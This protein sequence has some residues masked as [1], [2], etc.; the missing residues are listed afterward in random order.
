MHSDLRI[1]LVQSRLLWEDIPGN[2]A[3]FT[4]KI[5]TIPT[6]STD[7]I[8]LPETF[9]TGFSMHT[10]ELAEDEEGPSL[11]WMRVMASEKQAVVAGSIIFREGEQYF[12][13]FLWV[14]PD[15]S[16]SHYN[17]RHC[18]TLAGEQEHFTPGNARLIVECKGWRLCPM[19]CY[20]LRFPVWSRYRGDYDVLLYVANWPRPRNEAWKT[21]LRGRA[22]ENQCYTIGVNR[23]G[24]DEKGLAY[25]G[26]S[27]VIDYAGAPLYQASEVEGIFTLSLSAEKQ[28]IFRKKLAF[29]ADRDIFEVTI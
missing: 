6:G 3:A 29:L 25:S 5:K 21:L 22:I 28:Q 16:H 10:P 18:F 23:V 13:R 4:E 11:A 24:E 9:T 27:A 7:V 15:G 20:D 2:L 14:R 26:D 1:S 17:K 8:L 19:I 12:N